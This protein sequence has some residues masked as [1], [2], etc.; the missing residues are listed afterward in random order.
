MCFPADQNERE[1][2]LS[3]DQSFIVQAPAGSGKTQLLVQRYLRLLAIVHCPEEIIAIT[4]T[5]KAAREMK[6]RILDVL[7][8]AHNT[9]PQKAYETKKTLHL[10]KN[11]L[12]QSYNKNW[13]I[14]I[15]HSRLKITTID[16]FCQSIACKMP[17]LTEI[18]ALTEVIDEPY[19]LY[20]NAIYNMLKDINS[21]PTWLNDFNA[22]LSHLDNDLNHLFTL[23]Q[24]MLSQ[25]EQW[26]PLLL[27]F[28]KSKNNQEY[29]RQCENNFKAIITTQLKQIC[30]YF[31]TQ[32][33]SDLEKLIE[34]SE[35][36]HP[37]GSKQSDQ[38]ILKPETDY[39]TNWHK[40]INLLL[41][42]N[43][44]YRQTNG[45]NIKHG[46]PS[47]SHTKDKQKQ[48]LYKNKKE[49][50]K[51]FL[52][53]IKNNNQLLTQL[54][55]LKNFPS[56]RY[57]EKEKSI[58][59]SIINILIVSAQYLKLEF[60]Q[61]NC[62]DFVEFNIAAVNA[63]GNDKN[64]TEIGL[65]LDHSISHIL[66]D[67]F[68][69]TSDIQFKLL[70][71][72][73]SQ[74]QINE[75]KTLFVVGDPMQSIYRFRQAEV[76]LFVE[77]QKKGI[78]HLKLNCLILNQNFRSNHLLV[79]WINETFQYIFPGE[80]NQYYSAIKYV[81]SKSNK[82]SIYQYPVELKSFYDRISE[83]E[84]IAKTIKKANKQPDIQTI[85]VLCR[86]RTQLKT[87]IPILDKEDIDYSE[88]D[89]RPID[90]LNVIRD[91]K[92][93]TIAFQ[94]L[95]DD[96]SWTSLLHSPLVGLNLTEI[97]KLKQQPEQFLSFAVI[98]CSPSFVTSNAI[99]IKRLS[100]IQNVLLEY[101]NFHYTTNYRSFI[102]QIWQQLNG[103]QLYPQF[104]NHILNFFTILESHL[105]GQF[106]LD[107]E[108]F[109]NA[110]KKLQTS[111]TSE[112]SIQIM[113]IHKAKGLEFDMVILPDLNYEGSNSYKPLLMHEYYWDEYQQKQYLLAPLYNMN[114]KQQSPIYHY[115]E[116]INQQRSHYEEQRLLYVAATRAKQKLLLTANFENSNIKNSSFLS[117]LN[118]NAWPIN[119]SPWET[120][121][122]NHKSLNIEKK[123]Q[124]IEKPNITYINAYPEVKPYDLNHHIDK[125]Q[126]GNIPFKPAT[127]QLK[128]IIGAIV[129][130]QLKQMMIKK[131]QY[132][133]E[134]CK[135]EIYRSLIL[136][137]VENKQQSNAYHQIIQAL[138]N[139]IM[140]TAGAWLLNRNNN[141]DCY[142]EKPIFH[143]AN[144]CEL[145]KFIPDIIIKDSYG[146]WWIID[147]KTSK[148]K[149]EHDFST[150]LHIE[151]FKYQKQLDQYA[152]LLSKAGCLPIRKALFFTFIPFF[153]EI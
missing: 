129:H 115:I 76:Q 49:Q 94:L 71:K 92:A 82:E 151:S 38:I 86:A 73:V 72:L 110:I 58:I 21:K 41:K 29:L 6:T 93:L 32:E 133:T 69:D 131:D 84:Y 65:Y 150:F 106:H 109:L 4:F 136:Y 97:S 132:V 57:T 105:Y 100:V 125:P 46:F 127:D 54:Q 59:I 114:K 89:T 145:K 123:S 80:D 108:S 22:L 66:I 34:F 62:V 12:E 98:Q 149:P 95:N 3:P 15:N 11:A 1:K 104:E 51:K 111:D 31:S 47:P 130:Q 63:L 7:N 148:P 56:Y 116:K 124:N 143:I 25:R 128:Q 78:G 33:L 126:T 53:K 16:A 10:A 139:V 30:Q 28:H 117:I 14:L 83:S 18:N 37:N 2:A 77:I 88:H 26:L 81:P 35:H 8:Q 39:L 137:G 36:H 121:R 67:E 99:K 79:K 147:Y 144:T 55:F 19:G 118:N 85:A 141:I 90:K 48:K 9:D 5:R 23:L 75:N 119:D 60:A 96:T 50:L 142:A 153:Y 138:D 70:K 146:C 122:C 42:Q 103:H 140:H 52:A 17:S 74:W 91:L 112:K 44:Q 135:Q 45:I 101:L 107:H 13:E 61:K 43:G 20:Y 134:K 24:D 27:D 102:E 152:N 113:T 64:P 68:Q 40:L 120:V 87:L